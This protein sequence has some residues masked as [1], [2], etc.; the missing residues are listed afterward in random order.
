MATWSA[1]VLGSLGVDPAR[2]EGDGRSCATV[3]DDAERLACYDRIFRGAKA[4][5][6]V[7]AAVATA[8]TPPAA[9]AAPASAAPVAP[10]AP[11][12]AAQDF[13]LTEAQKQA[14]E[15]ESS[16][17]QGPSSITATIKNVQT[18]HGGQFVVILDNDQVWVQNDPAIRAHLK[19]GQSVEI[20]KAAFGSHLLVPA[21]RPAVRVRRVK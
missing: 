11:R 3:T 16:R 6:P 13:G 12:D 17:D 4:D 8:A 9:P 7:P 10:A 21:N 15:P 2:A 19:K 1:V 5:A 20:R 14:R 18:L